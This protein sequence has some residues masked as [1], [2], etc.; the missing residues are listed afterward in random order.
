MGSHNSL[1]KESFLVPTAFLPQWLVD[2]WYKMCNQYLP[3]PLQS[4]FAIELHLLVIVEDSR[5]PNWH[6]NWNRRNERDRLKHLLWIV[7][8]TVTCNR[9]SLSVAKR[10][11]VCPNNDELLA[12]SIGE[13][14]RAK[15]NRLLRN[16]WPEWVPTWH[17]V[18]PWKMMMMWSYKK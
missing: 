12:V 16:C 7:P 11:N 1:R 10:R 8:T 3:L 15:R 17:T 14:S 6:T 18:P 2:W 5:A 4:M 9:H 13:C